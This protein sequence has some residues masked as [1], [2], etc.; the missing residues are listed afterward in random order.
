LGLAIAARSAGNAVER[1]RIRRIVRE[2]F[3]L[4]AQALPAV[5]IIVG[6]RTG[7]RSVPSKALRSSLEALWLKVATQW[8]R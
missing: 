3:R 2:S 6:T 1:N 8:A 5:D 7:V 4:H